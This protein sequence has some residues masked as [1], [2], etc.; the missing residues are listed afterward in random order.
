MEDKIYIV[1]FRSPGTPHRVEAATVKREDGRF[2]F[3]NTKGEETGNF[4]DTDVRGYSL[5][6]EL[7]T[8]E[9]G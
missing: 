5:E 4:N 1:S 9:V 7:P 3:T 8:F 6:P 2:I